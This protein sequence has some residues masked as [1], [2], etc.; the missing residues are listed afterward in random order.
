LTNSRQVSEAPQENA[1]T[2]H[3]EETAMPDTIII[4]RPN[5]D[6]IEIAVSAAEK[7]REGEDAETVGH[8][9]LYLHER[10]KHLEKVYEHINHYLH[11]GQAPREHS[12]LL[13]A[14]E[15]TE[16]F[17]HPHEDAP[18]VFPGD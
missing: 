4:K 5:P 9:L 6:Q 14:I 17:A 3:R 8:Y 12:M 2:L 18:A 10:N 15:A 13:R 1:A 16:K 7:L 11:S